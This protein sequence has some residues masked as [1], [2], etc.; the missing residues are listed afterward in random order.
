MATTKQ[1][2]EIINNMKRVFDDYEVKREFLED[3]FYL[4]LLDASTIVKQKK[5]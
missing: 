4:K 1:Y 5:N 2:R 3:E